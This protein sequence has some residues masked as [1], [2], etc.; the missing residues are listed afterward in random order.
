MA[1]P[2]LIGYR[3]PVFWSE[4]WQ[5]V[6]IDESQRRPCD[7]RAGPLQGARTGVRRTCASKARRPLPAAR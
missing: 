6:D 3:R 7:E 1:Q 2:W 5:Y 4:W